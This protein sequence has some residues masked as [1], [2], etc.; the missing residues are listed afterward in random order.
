[1]LQKIISNMVTRK[2]IIQVW[3]LILLKKFLNIENFV[4]GVDR[5]ICLVLSKIC[6]ILIFV[7]SDFLKIVLRKNVL[8]NCSKNNKLLYIEV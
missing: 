5:L 4:K 8:Q 2:T 3:N 7:L 1:M 6:I